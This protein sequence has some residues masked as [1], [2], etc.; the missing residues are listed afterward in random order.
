MMIGLGLGLAQ[1][2]TSALAA[3]AVNGVSP[4]YGLIA[5]SGFDNTGLTRTG[6]E[7]WIEGADGQISLIAA[8][9][10]S[11]D[12]STGNRRYLV[13]DAATNKCTNYNVTPSDLTN[14][15]GT[16][17]SGGYTSIVTAAE[18][19][20]A[21]DPAVT[22]LIKVD[23]DSGGNVFLEFGGSAGNTNIHTLSYIYKSSGNGS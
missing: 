22:H 10:L 13:E 5:P 15:N 6:D 20:W 23:N 19:G 4:L 11:Y 1:I 3:Y 12:Y 21:G 17:V 16:A 18:A 8:N 9:A 2:Q 7:K 14:L